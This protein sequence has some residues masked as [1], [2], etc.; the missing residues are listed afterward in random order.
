LFVG[1]SITG[2]ILSGICDGAEGLA[3]RAAGGYETLTLTVLCQVRKKPRKIDPLKRMVAW[4]LG[5]LNSS[6]SRE[7]CFSV[8][9]QT[10]P[11]GSKSVFLE[12][13][14]LW[15][16]QRRWADSESFRPSHSQF[17][18]SSGGLRILR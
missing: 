14:Y 5:L 13:G 1:R 17:Q 12:V 18:P 9:I 8:P 11:I 6:P 2:D 7:G 15:R 10:N 4:N 16:R 3:A